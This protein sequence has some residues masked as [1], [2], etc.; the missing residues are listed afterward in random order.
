MHLDMTA[1]DLEQSLLEIYSSQTRAFKINLSF[2]FIMRH[3]E[4]NQHRYFRPYGNQ[5]V[6]DEPILISNMS[7]LRRVIAKLA[8]LDPF[9]EN[10]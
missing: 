3:I 9:K 6:F 8:E 10:V 5:S 2:G 1:H 7:D 4:T